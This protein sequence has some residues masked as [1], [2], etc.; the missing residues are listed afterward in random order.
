MDAIGGYFELDLQ[1]GAYFH[2]NTLNINTGRNAFEFILGVRRYKKV[3]LPYYTCEVLLE[4]L[5]KIKISYDF[6]HIN[7]YLE[8]ISYPHL[9]PNEAFLYTNYY[10]LKQLCVE[11]LSERYG[12]QLIV[13]NAQAFYAKPLDGVDTFYS[14]RKFFG[15]PDGGYVC[16]SRNN[17]VETFYDSLPQDQSWQRMSHLLKRLDVSAEFGFEDFHDNSRLLTNAQLQ[18]MSSLTEALLGNINYNCAR[19]KRI[20]NFSY[21]HNDLGQSNK[22]CSVIDTFLNECKDDGCPMVYPYWTDKR[23]LRRCLI[24]NRIYVATYW[25]NVARWCDVISLEN[26][27]MENL[28]PLPIDQRYGI[29]DMKHITNIIHNEK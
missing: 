20:L 18:R 16:L 2:K 17:D 1:K 5:S 21:L 11:K 26:D 9:E 27:L 13:D 12:N 8:P 23:E 10:G 29:S 22:L 15:V 24:E 19:H 14:P 7:E 4:P 25:P 28:I 3:Y 6:Y